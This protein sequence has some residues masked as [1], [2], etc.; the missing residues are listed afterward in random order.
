MATSATSSAGFGLF[1]PLPHLSTNPRSSRNLPSSLP[2]EASLSRK[3]QQISEREGEDAA[4]TGG[5]RS[6]HRRLLALNLDGASRMRPSR[7][8]V[9]AAQILSA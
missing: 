5:T 7:A 1:S 4:I 9:L 6:L 8:V 2:P 3:L